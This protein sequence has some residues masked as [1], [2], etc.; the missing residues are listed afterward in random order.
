[1]SELFPQLC[2]L[3]YVMNIS[4]P[5]LDLTLLVRLEI[6]FHPFVD[7]TMARSVLILLAGC[8]SFLDRPLHKKS[9]LMNRTI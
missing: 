7:S 6:P 5:H 4:V 9:Y 8:R 1:M 3:L 2:I